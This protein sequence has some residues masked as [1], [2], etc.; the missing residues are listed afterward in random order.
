M[1]HS[2]WVIVYDSWRRVYNATCIEF[3][4]D[5][6]RKFIAL[7][8]I[9]VNGLSPGTHLS[10]RLRPISTD[11][12][13]QTDS[14]HSSRC[15]TQSFISNGSEHEL[16]HQVY[17]EGKY[18]DSSEDQEEPL[19]LD[20]KF[21]LCNE[22]LEL[23]RSCRYSMAKDKRKFISDQNNKSTKLYSLRRT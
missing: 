2:L 15:S 17:Y 16:E 8:K 13:I 18:C 7:A 5:T 3:A 21:L 1:S 22:S 6:Q 4:K 19:D 23:D 20:K 9:I 14:E 12:L 11:S 10:S